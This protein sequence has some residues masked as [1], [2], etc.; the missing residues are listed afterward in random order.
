[1]L[2]ARA[3]THSFASA[4]LVRAAGTVGRLVTS[5]YRGRLVDRLGPSRTLL[6]LLPPATAT[7][8]GFI[9]VGRARPS[10]VALVAAAA[11]AG[12]VTAP[13]GT[14][15]R[16]V[17]TALLPDTDLRRAGFAL[18]S[19]LG[20]ISFFTGRCSPGC[21]SPPTRRRSTWPGRRSPA[22]TAARPR[23]GCACRCSRSAPGSAGSP[24]AP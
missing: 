21:S 11:A 22:S 20:E 1:M 7:D 10:A 3:A 6:W 19:V 9:L 17:W 13:A 12:A 23:R 14:V 15:N 8:V 4:S 16:T 5:P 2:F 24:T 18:M